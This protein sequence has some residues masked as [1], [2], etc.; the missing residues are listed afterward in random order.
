MFNIT[1]HNYTTHRTKKS[2]YREQKQN[3]ETSLPVHT[4]PK[5]AKKKAKHH[6]FTTIYRDK[7]IEKATGISIY[8]LTLIQ[9][10]NNTQKRKEKTCRNHDNIKSFT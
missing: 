5:R 7:K 4:V 1:K 8:F 6:T 9:F 10:H 3:F 2:I